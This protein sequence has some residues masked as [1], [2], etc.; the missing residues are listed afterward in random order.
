MLRQKSALIATESGTYGF[1][2]ASLEI[3]ALK[4]GQEESC[5]V[6]SSGGGSASQQ[7]DGVETHVGNRLVIDRWFISKN[8]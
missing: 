4:S 3:L 1:D 2:N 8:W 7:S 6:T 5:G